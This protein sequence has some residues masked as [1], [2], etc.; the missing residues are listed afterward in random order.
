MSI[1]T[2]SLT[3]DAAQGVLR[4]LAKKAIMNDELPRL[5]EVFQQLDEDGD[6]LVSSKGI[7]QTV[8]HDVKGKGHRVSAD[9][10]V[11]SAGLLLPVHDS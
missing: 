4:V 7:V 8:C 3:R 10:Y 11:H 5:L 9:L 2:R 1:Q 6:G